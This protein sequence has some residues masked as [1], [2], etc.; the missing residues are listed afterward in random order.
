MNPF[1]KTP[2]IFQTG[3]SDIDFCVALTLERGYSKKNLLCRSRGD[4]TDI[5][6]CS[7]ERDHNFKGNEYM[8]EQYWNI[9][10]RA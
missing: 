4:I 1:G 10:L 9:L 3:N 2:T 6:L 7:I 5:I 8:T